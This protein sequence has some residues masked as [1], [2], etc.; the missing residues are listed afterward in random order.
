[1]TKTTEFSKMGFLSLCLSAVAARLGPEE[2]AAVCGP[3]AATLSQ[4]ISK[5][6]QPL[7]LRSLADGLWAVA[8][9]L[10]PVEAAAVCGPAAATLSQA[11]VARS[12]PVNLRDYV[13]RGPYIDPSDEYWFQ[14]LAGGLSAV[15][16]RMG[17]EEAAAVC[18]PASAAL[19]QAMALTLNSSVFL[20]QGLAE[21]LLRED[22]TPV[23]SRATFGPHRQAL[24]P[25][26]PPLPSH[27]LV[28]LLK[29]PFCVGKA[30]RLVLGQLARHYQRPFADQWD[31]VRFAQEQKLPLDLLTP[32]QRPEL[33]APNR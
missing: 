10:G 24:E 16:A 1:M 26:P 17:A 14:I 32:P 6:K 13:N 31:F 5:T 12:Q 18:G 4:A 2:A 29:Q 22:L 25:S 3:A 21:V 19:M 9:R 20:E 27:M 33:A 8:A 7:E 15:A 11:I 23:R 28:D 30:R